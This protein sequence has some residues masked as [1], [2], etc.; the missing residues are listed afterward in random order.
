MLGASILADITF[1][2]E[3]A[4]ACYKFL[5]H[6][7]ETEIRLVDPSKKLKPFSIFVHCESDFVAACKQYN[8]KY[9]LYVGINE[10]NKEGTTAAEVISVKTVVI[11]IDA[12]RAQGFEHDPA[13]DEELLKAEVICNRI[14]EDVKKFNQP[15]FR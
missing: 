2:E 13:T 3:A 12:I 7:N 5:N 1:K 8:S 15:T 14:L 6:L 11:D 4:K 10:R 9:N